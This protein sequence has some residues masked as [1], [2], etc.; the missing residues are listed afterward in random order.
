MNIPKTCF[1]NHLFFCY[2]RRI[3]A[4]VDGNTAAEFWRKC[5]DN[6]NFGGF[7]LSVR[8]LF[9]YHFVFDQTVSYSPREES[10]QH[11]VIN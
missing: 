7:V 4:S 8:V 6:R 5:I 10:G 3:T 9:V 2:R 11:R 1:R